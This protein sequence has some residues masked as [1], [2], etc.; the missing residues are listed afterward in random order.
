[1]HRNVLSSLRIVFWVYLTWFYLKS[2]RQ[3][4]KYKYFWWSTFPY[5]VHWQ[6]PLGVAG[7]FV[8]VLSQTEIFQFWIQTNYF[9]SKKQERTSVWIEG[10]MSKA[11][12]RP[13]THLWESV[14]LTKMKAHHDTWE[15]GL[16]CTGNRI[17]MLYSIRNRISHLYLNPSFTWDHTRSDSWPIYS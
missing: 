1:M 11:G 2:S 6:N 5:S 10:G 8:L 13:L 14:I 7:I 9:L 4:K 3:K 16:Y 15:L 17:I 12:Q